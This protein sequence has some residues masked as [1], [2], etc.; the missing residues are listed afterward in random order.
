[1]PHAFVLRYGIVVAPDRLSYAW[2][3]Q[4]GFFADWRN[5]SEHLQ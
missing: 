2:G 5:H 3:N 1:M 4:E